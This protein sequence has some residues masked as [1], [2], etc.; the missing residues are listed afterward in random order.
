MKPST[1]EEAQVQSALNRLA[2]EQMKHRLLADLA[3]DM[4][5]CQLE[6]YDHT[7]YV[8]EI[9]QEME[10]MAVGFSKGSELVRWDHRCGECGARISVFDTE[11][12][13]CHAEFDMSKP[14]ERYRLD[15]HDGC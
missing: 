9:I 1:D 7:E 12:K 8:R 4:Q 6:G 15:L 14:F 2:R 5:V 11:C 10:R 13:R 3:F